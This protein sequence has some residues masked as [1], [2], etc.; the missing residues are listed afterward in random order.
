MI[1]MSR[2]SLATGKLRDNVCSSPFLLPGLYY[3]SPSIM[4][5]SIKTIPFNKSCLLKPDQR[6]PPLGE[7]VQWRW[8]KEKRE[9]SIFYLSPETFH[10]TSIPAEMFIKKYCYQKHFTKKTLRQK[11]FSD[12]DTRN[13]AKNIIA[14]QNTLKI[15]FS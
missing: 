15:L 12:S 13:I 7:I 6:N 9:W 1:D 3:L 8:G 2:N 14:V 4:F 11:Y 10:K 5:A